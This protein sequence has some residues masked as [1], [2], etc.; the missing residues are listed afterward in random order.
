MNGTI[1]FDRIED[2]AEFLKNMTGSTA[3]FVAYQ[4]REHD[5]WVVKFTGGC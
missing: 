1:T 3:T 5:K 2:M 4:D